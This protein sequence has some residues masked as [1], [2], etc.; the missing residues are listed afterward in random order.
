MNSTNRVMRISG[1]AFESVNAFFT[2]ENVYFLA[3]EDCVD[4]EYIDKKK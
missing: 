3:L 1:E 4:L 2:H